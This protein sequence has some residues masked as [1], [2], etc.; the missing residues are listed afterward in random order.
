MKLKIEKLRLKLLIIISKNGKKCKK[1]VDFF[2]FLLYNN[3]LE[4]ILIK[5]I[6]KIKI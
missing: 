3:T 1:D 5:H 2:A 4:N 6:H